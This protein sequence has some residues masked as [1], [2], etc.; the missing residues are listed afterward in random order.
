V[1]KIMG[2]TGLSKLIKGTSARLESK[3]GELAARGKAHLPGATAADKNAAEVA[4]FKHQMVK[5]GGQFQKSVS[6]GFSSASSSISKTYSSA[7]AS[8]TGEKPPGT[9][10]KMHSWWKGKD[11]TGGSSLYDNRMTQWFNNKFT[12]DKAQ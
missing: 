10:D 7:K 1:D 6:D 4:K 5:G 2:C 11:N 8:I 9:L 3:A 12:P